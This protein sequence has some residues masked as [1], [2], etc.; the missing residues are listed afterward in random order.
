MMREAWRSA[1]HPESSIEASFRYF[2]TPQSLARLTTLTWLARWRSFEIAPCDKP[3]QNALPT[4][5]VGLRASV[6]ASSVSARLRP[7]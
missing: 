4:G 3:V 6:R 1:D 5:Q 7:R 2:Q